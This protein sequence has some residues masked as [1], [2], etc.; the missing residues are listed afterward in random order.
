MHMLM[1]GLGAILGADGV[2]QC[3]H[4]ISNMD[5]IEQAGRSGR[6]VKGVTG[7]RLGD[8][9]PHGAHCIGRLGKIDG[10]VD[11]MKTEHTHDPPL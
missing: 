2:P 6:E 3:I 5:Q 9:R 10:A 8:Q 7:Q 4:R 1:S 11:V